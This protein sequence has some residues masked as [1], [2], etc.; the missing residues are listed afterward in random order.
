MME[1]KRNIAL[2]K[3]GFIMDKLNKELKI[4]SILQGNTN[5]ENPMKI[6]DLVKEVYKERKNG[7]EDSFMQPECDSRNK[8]SDNGNTGTDSKTRYDRRVTILNGIMNILSNCNSDY[9]IRILAPRVKIK[10]EEDESKT[11]KKG[12]KGKNK[13][14]YINK[15]GQINKDKSNKNEGEPEYIEKIIFP[16]VMKRNDEIDKI[17]K[18]DF[19]SLN[20]AIKELVAVES[21]SKEDISN[22]IYDNSIIATENYVKTSFP[23]ICDWKIYYQQSFTDVEAFIILSGLMNQKNIESS[24]I[25]EIIRKLVRNT[26]DWYF[27]EFVKSVNLEASQTTMADEYLPTTLDEQ[28]SKKAGKD[29][30]RWYVSDN[31]KAVMDAIKQHKKINFNRIYY[32]Y[33]HEHKKWVQKIP[34]TEE[35]KEQHNGRTQNY[36]CT[37]LKIFMEEGR[38]WLLAVKDNYNTKDGNFMP[39]PLDLITNIQILEENGCPLEEIQFIEKYDGKVE[40]KR[41]NEYM[42]TNYE[43][44]EEFTIELRKNQTAANLVLRTFGNDFEYVGSTDDY[45][46]IK[47]VR[48]PFGIINWALVNTRDVKLIPKEDS[49]KERM[50]QKIEEI[51]KIYEYLDKKQNKNEN[52]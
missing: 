44:P 29:L 25:N 17:E 8:G 26:S 6:D 42:K 22:I 38:Y 40:E 31:I 9:P 33:D 36:T 5:K 20:P 12:K 28:Q 24:K 21:V 45:D 19:E 35:Y 41:L 23:E 39:C 15:Y 50:C 51:N 16:S 3:R 11:A 7:N 1:N 46:V 4:I 34:T 32:S 48:S 14:C 2:S 27:E 30:Q 13:I 52:P 10:K 37:P 18:K 49:T 47:V 43:R